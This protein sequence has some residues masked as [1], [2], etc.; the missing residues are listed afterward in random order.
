M[1]FGLSTP[2]LDQEKFYQSISHEGGFDEPY[3]SDEIIRSAAQHCQ[4]FTLHSCWQTDAPGWAENP[5]AADYTHPKP[6]ATDRHVPV[7]PKEFGRVRDESHRQGMQFIPY[8]SPYFS[9]A[10]DIFAEMERVLEEYE[11]DGLYFDGSCGHREDFRPHYHL[12]RRA[13]AILG[14]RLL[15]LHSSAEP[16]STCRVY[17]PFVY[18]YADFVL[19][20]EAGR[21]GLDLGEF[22]R[23]TV[24][25]YQIS[26]SV[27]MWCHYGSWSDQLSNHIVPRTEHIEMAL[28]HH[29]RI[30]RCTQ[31]WSKL[32][33]ELARFDREYYGGLSRLQSEA[34]EKNT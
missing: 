31:A 11:V 27:G 13:R 18:A 28:R 23:Y 25:Q 10:P 24:S 33:E 19:S 6:W 2:A 9:N 29:V 7:D 26:N 20:G 15:Y 3:P 8:L 16:F 34:A 30:W 22:L 32:P 4:I 14:D 17:L 1:G 12:M 21:F 5:P